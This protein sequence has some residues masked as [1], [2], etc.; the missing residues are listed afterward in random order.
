VLLLQLAYFVAALVIFFLASWPFLDEMRN[1]EAFF[2]NLRRLLNERRKGSKFL[3]FAFLNL[4]ISFL[5][6]F[7]IG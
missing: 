1:G 2:T 5:S 7:V 3:A 6:F 4:L